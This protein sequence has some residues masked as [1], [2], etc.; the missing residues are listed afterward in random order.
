MELQER[1]DNQDRLVFK[2]SPEVQAFLEMQVCLEALAIKVP[3][4]LQDKQAAG[5]HQDFKVLQ[6]L[7][8][9]QE[10]QVLYCN[11]ILKNYTN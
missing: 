10:I 9:R 1:M 8:V 6:E 5:E 7:P 3:K 11:L 4:D 2:D